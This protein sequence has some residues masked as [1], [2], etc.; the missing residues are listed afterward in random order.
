[1]NLDR[2]EEYRF[3]VDSMLGRLAKWLRILGWD[4]ILTFLKTPEEIKSFVSSGRTVITKACR[5]C[6][7]NGVICLKTNNI[8]DQL[9]ELFSILRIE[10]RPDNFLARCIRCNRELEECSRMQAYGKV[11]EY[12]WN[13]IQ[14]FFR[15][16]QC[17][18]IYWSGSH[19][20]RMNIHI[21]NWFDTNTS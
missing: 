19:V 3:V 17:G 6:H 21:K 13:T 16:P 4:T 8:K 2:K 7:I 5:W 9:K 15:C 14:E 12:V 20:N 11:P 1:M 18:K 10:Y